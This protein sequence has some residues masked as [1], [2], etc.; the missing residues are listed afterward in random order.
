MDENASD[1]QE[2]EDAL[3][4]SGFLLR[5]LLSY[6]PDSIYFKDRHSRFIQIS[7]SM[8][9]KFNFPDQHSVIGKTD[10]DIFSR[11]HAQQAL[12]DEREIMRSRE[13]L[14]AKLERETW[15]DG[16]DTWCSTTKMPLMDER[17]RVVGTFGISSDV[18]E[19]KRALD[20]AEAERYLLHSLMDNVPDSIYFKDIHGRYLRVNR[21]KALRSGLK[22]PEEA[23]GK[24]DSDVFSEEHAN[25]TRLDELEVIHSNQAVIGQEQHLQWP[26]GTQSWVS[27]SKFPLRDQEGKVI[28]TFG[29]SHDITGQKE[30]AE[31]M[32]T[33]KE[34]AEAASRAKSDFLANMSH[35]IRTPMNG[36]IGMGELL[37][38]T[39]LNPQQQS[40]VDMIQQSAQSLLGLINDI[41]DFS[42][43]EAGK[44]ELEMIPFHIRDSVG[45]AVKSLA[46][47]SSQKGLE[48]I[49]R[50]D[51]KVPEF[52]FGDPARLRQVLVNL[53]GN[54]VKFTESGE[55]VVNVQY[56]CGPPTESMVTLLFSVRDTGIGI[57]SHLQSQIFEA[58]S[59]ADTT[60]TR[61]Y[62]GTGLGLSI[63]SQ[64]VH[65]M[66]GRIWVES[67]PSLRKGSEFLFNLKLE[68]APEPEGSTT[69]DRTSLKG[70]MVLVV[71]DNRTN[72]SIL[73]ETLRRF[74]MLVT[75][76]ESG[77]AAMDNYRSLK[78]DATSFALMIVDRMMPNMDG[79]Q[80]LEKIAE[81]FKER[82]PPT[83][84]Y[85]SSGL[86]E[87][88]P[89]ATSL[90]VKVFLQKPALQAEI[91]EAIEKA[92]G[93]PA[94]KS[95]D[96][97][98]KVVQKAVNPMRFLVAEDGAVNRAVAK[99]LFAR[100]GHELVMVENGAEAIEAWKSRSFD[101]I[102]MDIQMPVLDGIE[103]TRAIRDQESPGEH[104]PII[105]MTAAAMKGD[106]ERFLAEEMD[107][108]LSKPIDFEEFDNMLTRL[109]EKR[110]GKNHSDDDD[111]VL[112]PTHSD[113]PT[114]VPDRL[115][116][117]ANGHSAKTSKRKSTGGIDFSA[118]FVRLKCSVD[119][120]KMLVETLLTELRQRLDE[121][122]RG[123]EKSDLAL[124]IRAAHSLKSA[125][126][127]IGAKPLVAVA[128]QLEQSARNGDLASV[129]E[130]FP[131]LRNLASQ[132][133]QEIEEWLAVS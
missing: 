129:A 19:R 26:D 69:L 82:L 64:L 114:N 107:D 49:L 106:R 94:T 78:P 72:L 119:Q 38:D 18:T 79:M 47:R 131:Q 112:S 36:I 48:L 90:G 86:S 63:S 115:S 24:S 77:K 33:A 53:V 98:K 17:G 120:Q 128:N 27:T 91:L 100:A 110:F 29:I 39:Q 30:A 93:K 66:G 116:T 5:T 125:V 11:E 51:P 75:L 81:E 59:Q 101:A 68:I 87:D 7:Q 122:V 21:A 50:I 95:S 28:G 74:G 3:Q 117:V 80:L 56:A 61:R 31:Q 22:S 13:P 97:E 41:L 52:V 14:V 89:R 4:D 71:D 43:I 23:I 40:F 73:D 2:I 25:R 83:I 121:I 92:L 10:A 70:L 85:S 113:E 20:E 88:G 8:A 132:V 133:Q 109:S 99:G 6:M 9:R 42:K 105:A 67:E 58:F 103:A 34:A 45:M 111:Q 126:G 76:A 37:A 12:A 1:G 46:P 44:L 124:M 35:E 104:I 60:T 96:R 16:P 123:L 57:E 55:I 15:P 102:F 118:P 130:L 108:Y 32:R 84:L 127:L 62:G 65:L 54:A